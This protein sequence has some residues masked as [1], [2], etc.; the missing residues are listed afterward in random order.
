MRCFCF[1]SLF[2]QC[3]KLED[4]KADKEYVQTEVEVVRTHLDISISK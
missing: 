4:S 3:S 1:Q 2:E